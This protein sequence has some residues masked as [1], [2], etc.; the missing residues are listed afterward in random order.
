MSF[1]ENIY[2]KKKNGTLVG[3]ILYGLFSH[4]L[5][6]LEHSLTAIIQEQQEKILKKI[7]IVVVF[8]VGAWFLLQALALFISDYVSKGPWVGYSIVGGVLVILGL[9]FRE[10]E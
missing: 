5:D 9:I 8:F 10:R 1:E 6:F 4:T 3:S 7:G 2:R